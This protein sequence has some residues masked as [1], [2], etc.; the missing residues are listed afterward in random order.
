MV[1]GEEHG[2]RDAAAPECAEVRCACHNLLARRRGRVIELKCRRCKRV[3]HLELTARGGV[4][5]RHST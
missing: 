5:L 2:T 3:L 4:T 1:R